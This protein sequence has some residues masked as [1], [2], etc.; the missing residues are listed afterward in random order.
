[1]VTPEL[2]AVRPDRAGDALDDEL[3]DVA[4]VVRQALSARVRDGLEREELVQETLTRV[5][6]ARGRLDVSAMAP[7]A[8]VVARNL[9]NAEARRVGRAA[10]YLPRLVDLDLS[11]SVEDETVRA[12]E[13]EAIRRALASLP[14]HDRSL[15]VAHEVTDISTGE[16]AAQQSTSSGAIAVRLARSRAQL[17]VEYLLAFRSV[18]D[19]PTPACR[20]VLVA[21]SSGDR[22]RQRALG[23]GDHLVD[24]D[25]CRS[26]SPALLERRRSLA[27]L[28]PF[29]L[30]R[31]A[32]VRLGHLARAH[33]VQTATGGVVVTAAILGGAALASTRHQRPLTSIGAAA[34]ATSIA[35]GPSASAAPVGIGPTIPP[36]AATPPPTARVA[37]PGDGLISLADGTL[38]LP[39]AQGGAAALAAREGQQV[40]VRHAPV[41]ALA[42]QVT[43]GQ[44][45]DD[46][47][48]W[49]G[50]SPTDRVL[51]FLH[52][53]REPATE[54][55]PG[56]HLSLSGRLRRYQPNVDDLGVD[57][58][59][60]FA[61]S[62]AGYYVEVTDLSVLTTDPR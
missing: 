59:Q 61:L 2:G 33:P 38:L 60:R 32:I 4:S 6:A 53:G 30:A 22:R 27:G 52:A 23:A 24:C 58:S 62:A 41:Q 1:M 48:L 42:G 31:I 36:A 17:R 46:E 49:V 21:L 16:L 13:R 20:P 57:P 5:L 47:R 44:G 18:N 35:A 15:L 45:A 37:Q 39:L 8:V 14:V 28:L 34:P 9:V 56:M 26:L 10:R 29:A 7:Y 50:P 55:A 40:V 25:A 43:P 54:L 51:V 12:S 3:M 11:P 19:L